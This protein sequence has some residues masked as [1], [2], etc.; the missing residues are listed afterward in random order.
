[1]M[2]GDERLEVI[3]S[4]C[5]AAMEA[6]ATVEQLLDR[7]P[8]FAAQLDAPLR[9]AI[10]L[11]ELGGEALRTQPVAQAPARSRFMARAAA[12][13]PAPRRA[14]SASW[15]LRPLVSFVTVMVLVAVVGGGVLGASAASLPGDPL[16]GVKRSFEA[17]QL[18][19]VRDPARQVSLEESYALRRVEEVKAVQS[20]KR[21]ASVQFT[22]LVEAVNGDVWTIGG[23]AVQFLPDTVVHGAPRVGELVEVA[24]RT[25]SDGQIVADRIE[26]ESAEFIGVVEAMGAPTW[27]VGG[28]QILVTAQT[29]IVGTAR[30]G[31][32][33][34]VHVQ[35]LPNGIVLALKIDF[36]HQ[37][38]PTVTPQ[39][40]GTPMPRPTSTLRP[41]LPPQELPAATR[42]RERTDATPEPKATNDRGDDGTPEPESTEDHDGDD[43]PEPKSTEDHDGGSTPEP[44]STKDHDNESTPEPDPAQDHGKDGSGSSRDAGED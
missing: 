22:A 44:E 40:A 6:G 13:R 32:P 5:L 20:S 21:A 30:L 7:Y 1:M 34:E 42:E 25:R 9:V 35:T 2:N 16:Y 28:R 27:T 3:L 10:R 39:P 43:T 41:T 29:Q 17:L 11:R 19:L 23:F 14:S 12:I 26:V 33:A 31:A 38:A 24:G 8:A 18:S 37:D 15:L 4:E 36:E